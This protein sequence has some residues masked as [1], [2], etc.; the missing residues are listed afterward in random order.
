MS[1]ENN[2]F[3]P[4]GYTV[5]KSDSSYVKLQQ[6]DNKFRILSKPIVGWVDWKDKKPF[7]FT[8]DKKPTVP[9]SPTQDIKHFWAFVVWDYTTKKISIFELTIKGIQ[10]RLA[11]LQANADWGAPFNYDVTI[12]K[13]GSTMGDTKYVLTPSPPKP[14][15]EMI[16]DLYKKTPINLQALFEDKDPFDVSEGTPQYSPPTDISSAPDEDDLPF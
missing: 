9:F 16:A 7:R 1:T 13:V 8:I 2:S 11:E 4:E 10:N 6:G 14:V 12:N 3:L 5:P 15:H